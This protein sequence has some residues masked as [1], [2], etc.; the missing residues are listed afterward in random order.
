[1]EVLDEISLLAVGGPGVDGIPWGYRRG[2]PGLWAYYPIEMEF[3]Y[4]AATVTALVET[5]AS[6]KLRL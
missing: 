4:V 6:G 3:T 5:W 1:V 2:E